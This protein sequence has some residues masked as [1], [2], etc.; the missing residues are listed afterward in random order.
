MWTNNLPF[1]SENDS[2]SVIEDNFKDVITLK[3][4]SAN[5]DFIKSPYKQNAIH[6]PQLEIFLPENKFFLSS[7]PSSLKLKLI[8]K[9]H[10][11]VHSLG[12]NFQLESIQMG[13][14]KMDLKEKRT[15]TL[16]QISGSLLGV[17]TKFCKLKINILKILCE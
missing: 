4:S 5:Y 8:V 7:I 3:Y 13:D 14:I 9:Y 2:K 17:P 11:T 6:K 15:L 1:Y 16:I 10:S 12:W